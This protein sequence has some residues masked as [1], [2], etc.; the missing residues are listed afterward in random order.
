[1]SVIVLEFEKS[2]KRVYPKG[3]IA[4][5]ATPLQLAMPNWND[6]KMAALRQI[7]I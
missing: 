1:M 4:P 6:R 5:Y 2:V 3:C 7:L